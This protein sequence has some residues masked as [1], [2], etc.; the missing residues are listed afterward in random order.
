MEIKAVIFDMDGLMTDTEKLL[1]KYWC[2][3]ANQL[4]FPMEEK[5]ALALRSYSRKFA[6]PKLKE[7]FGEACDYLA[8]RNLRVKLM[9]EYTDVHGVEKKKG[10]DELLDYLVANGYRTAVA[11]ATDVGRA[12]E[13]L[14]QLGV[15]DKFETIICGNMLEN[16]KPCPD[17]YLYACEQL[18]LPAQEC[19]ALED[20]PNGVKSASSAGCVTVMVPDL[21]QPEKEQLDVV[22]AVAESLDKVEGILEEI[23][24]KPHA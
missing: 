10:L 22:Y 7:W 12:S 15:Y 14:K 24:A 5:H 11:T 21:T 19:M 8:I 23:K 6:A 18:G 3:A 17:I 20:S 13:Y 4:G 16:G 9:K 2:M 1:V